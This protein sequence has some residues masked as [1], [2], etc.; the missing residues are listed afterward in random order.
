M[1]GVSQSYYMGQKVSDERESSGN[2]FA[3]MLLFLGQPTT[4]MRANGGL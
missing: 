1:F 2:G 4:E 3:Y